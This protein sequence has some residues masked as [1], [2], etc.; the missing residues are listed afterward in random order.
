LKALVDGSELYLT[1]AALRDAYAGAEDG[2]ADALR[3]S[4]W[5]TAHR[6]RAYAEASPLLMTWNVLQSD[7][8]LLDS[9]ELALIAKD[10][11]GARLSLSRFE[12]AWPEA[13]RAQ[14]FA[15]RVEK[16]RQGLAP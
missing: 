13:S 2:T 14:P 7:L 16:A 9:A 1:H 4:R 15:A 11:E 3:E 6:G 12:S 10:K 8:A 5:L